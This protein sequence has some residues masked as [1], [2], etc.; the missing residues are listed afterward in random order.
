[1]IAHAE[2]GKSLIEIFFKRW[3]G[4]VSCKIYD[5]I[6]VTFQLFYQFSFRTNV[7]CECYNNHMSRKSGMQNC[8]FEIANKTVDETES[9]PEG[10]TKKI[11][12]AK[13]KIIVIL[14][15]VSLCWHIFV[16][17]YLTECNTYLPVVSLMIKLPILKWK[18]YPGNPLCFVINC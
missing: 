15:I 6:R 9:K 4:K 12:L 11:G 13:I 8:I 18:T 14:L 5:L 1:M 3:Q 16:L 10:W 17:Y 7:W 2:F